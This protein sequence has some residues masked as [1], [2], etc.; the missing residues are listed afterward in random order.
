M[1]NEAERAQQLKEITAKFIKVQLIGSIGTI[2][3]GL[4]LYAIFG[5]QG[6]A[7]HPLL[8]DTDVA[9][10]MLIVGGVIMVWQYATIIPLMKKRVKLTKT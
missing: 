1:I 10:G 8:N 4:A 3:V 5:A 9:H 2:L 7:F 6:N